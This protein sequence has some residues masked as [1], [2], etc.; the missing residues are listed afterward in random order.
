MICDQLFCADQHSI[1]YEV[2]RFVVSFTYHDEVQAQSK[3]L[4]TN[5]SKV[6]LQQFCGSCSEFISFD[7]GDVDND[8]DYDAIQWPRHPSGEFTVHTVLDV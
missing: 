5:C 6:L 4:P 8:N 1:P 7:L 2:P 3:F